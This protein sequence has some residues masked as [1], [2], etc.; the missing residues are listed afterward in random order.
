MGAR[1]AQSRQLSSPSRPLLLAALSLS[2]APRRQE[3][4]FGGRSLH[5]VSPDS[6]V[7]NSA[8]LHLAHGGRNTDYKDPA[9]GFYKLLFSCHRLPLISSEDYKG[10]L[11]YNRSSLKEGCQLPDLRLLLVTSHNQVWRE[12]IR[13][14]GGGPSSPRHD[15]VPICSHAAGLSLSLGRRKGSHLR[16]ALAETFKQ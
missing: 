10:E 11:R 15:S 12:C 7:L 13:L 2:R 6:F 4:I 5:L 3:P 16:Q 9:N 1:G 14:R 8:A